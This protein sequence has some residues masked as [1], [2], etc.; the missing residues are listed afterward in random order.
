MSIMMRFPEGKSKVFTMSYDDG[1]YQ[2]IRFVDIINQH[3]LK[4]TFNVNGTLTER[5]AVKPYEKLSFRQVQEFYLS[6]GHEVALHSYSH[7]TL[8]DLPIEQVTYEYIKNR[9]I[10]EDCTGMI[11][12][13]SAYPNNKYNEKV[14]HSLKACGVAYARG[15]AQT[16]LFDIPSDWLQFMPTIK[17]WNPRLMELGETFLNLKTLVHHTCA[18]F[19]LMGHSYEFDRDNN[20]E[21]IGE[22]A[23]L[24]GGHDDVW[25]ATC[26][27]IYDYVKAFELLRFNLAKTIVYNP[28]S[29]DVWILRNY[30]LFKI[31][32]GETVSLN[33]TN[34]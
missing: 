13:G 21:V 18:M 25:Y 31:P 19:S 1:I 32:A 5:D 29:T 17:H 11:I 23:E 34:S 3:G 2:D 4:C 26:I 20:W 15:G 28:T 10:L 30:K 27:E 9:E 33:E 12:R 24:I 22:F 7:P 16:E 14:L 8:V 6:G